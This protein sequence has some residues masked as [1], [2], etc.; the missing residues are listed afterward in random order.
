MGIVAEVVVADNGSNDRSIEIERRL[1][2]SCMKNAR[3]TAPRFSKVLRFLL[4]LGL[5]TGIIRVSIGT[6]IDICMDLHSSAPMQD[7]RDHSTGSG[8]NLVLSSFLL[9]MM[10]PADR[11]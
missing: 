5:L 3:V 9:N 7:R 10:L 6:A 11:R 8:M 4:D 1:L 2:M